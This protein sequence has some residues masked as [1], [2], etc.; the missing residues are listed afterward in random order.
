MVL[1]KK[2]YKKT[3]IG[4]IPND[5]DVDNLGIFC[6]KITK[7]TTPT[8]YGFKYQDTGIN[9]IKVE[10]IDV[11]G[12][13]LTEI[14]T[15][16]NEE[17]NNYLKRSIL[18][19]NDLLFSIAGALGRV[20]KVKKDI[21][22]ANTNQALAI[23]RL[24]E[25]SSL[26]LNYLFYF[27]N[28]SQIQKHIE[29]IN[30]QSAQANLSLGDLNKFKI[31][32]PSSQ[33]QQKIAKILSTVD[34]DIEKTDAIIKET[35]QLKKG[36]MEKLF[37]EGIGHTRFKKTKIGRIPEKWEVVPF[38]KILDIKSGL[39]FKYSEYSDEGIKILKIDNVSYGEITWETVSYLPSNY[40]EK[41]PDLVLNTDDILLALN[42]PITQGRLKI[43]RLN[44]V[45]LPCIL[46]QRVG[47]IIFL[48]KE[49]DEAFVYH[50]LTQKIFEFVERTSVGSDQPFIRLTELRKY[51]L[52]IPPIKE[53]KKI[54]T[55]LSE[56]DNKIENEHNTKAELEQL[57][58][59][60]L[61]V[62]LTGKARVKV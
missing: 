8:T 49:I 47:K 59:G 55:I 36:L 18:K 14:F 28:G 32:L 48:D 5:W 46:Y 15:H 42:R 13:F 23:I 44:E 45:D 53:Q 7:G 60:L 34:A 27:L 9:F 62:L 57:K 24:K 54:A 52:T 19:E 17:A 37:T 11:N 41:Y 16:I 10:S 22:P 30:V 50:L 38:G 26:N 51:R 3:K 21:L 1:G 31:L 61:Q 6:D 20:A 43:G 2:Q 4:F 29:R 12:N 40:I 58:K 35:Q 33:E 39:G 56:I 25:K